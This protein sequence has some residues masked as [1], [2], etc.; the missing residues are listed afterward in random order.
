MQGL[1]SSP[2]QVLSKKHRAVLHGVPAARSRAQ[3]AG[4]AVRSGGTVVCNLGNFFSS[5]T[6]RAM[7][8]STPWK[9][10]DYFT[11]DRWWNEG[12]VAVV[13]GGC[14]LYGARQGKRQLI[15]TGLEL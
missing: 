14:A 10:P 7:S 1:F 4:G 11:T 6:K 12:T 9:A 2:A 8:G 3:L 13:S 5:V 15:E